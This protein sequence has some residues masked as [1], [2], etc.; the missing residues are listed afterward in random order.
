[1]RTALML[2]MLLASPVVARAQ[3]WGCA[4]SGRVDRRLAGTIVDFTK[5]HGGRGP[6]FSPILGMPRDLYVYLPPGYTPSRSYPLILY[7]HLAYVDEHAFIGLDQIEELDALIARGEIPPVIVAAPDG[8]YSGVNHYMEKHSLFI[9]GCGGRVEDHIMQEVV[10]FLMGRYSIRPE[11]EAHGILGVS[12]GGFG[13]LSL[14]MRRRDFFGAVATLSAPVNLRYDTCDGNPREDFD[15]ATYRWKEVYD[16]NEIMGVFYFGLDTVRARKYA[17]PVFGEGPEVVGRIKAVN[18]ADLLFTSGLQPGEL[19]I[20]LNYAGRDNWNF[21]A[22]AESFAWLA[23]QRGI[24]VT[25]ARDPNA[26][27]SLRYFRRNHPLAYCW[28]GRLL[29][30]PTP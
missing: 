23:G 5:N 8:T 17:E 6:I 4:N 24:P 29:L 26:T 13:A 22:H 27:H 2:L 21:D 7:Y 16:P 30:P 15:P 18:P 19:A 20:Y 9:N 1:M 3:L 11:R 10:P 28:L 12:A 25:L 14:A